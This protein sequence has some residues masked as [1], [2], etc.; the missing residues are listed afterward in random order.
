VPKLPS[1]AVTVPSKRMTA[2]PV[3]RRAGLVTTT[4][5]TSVIPANFADLVEHRPLLPQRLICWYAPNPQFRG[6]QV[7]DSL[8]ARSHLTAQPRV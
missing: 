6:T 8:T 7:D 2:A 4:L 1:I 3:P 5:K